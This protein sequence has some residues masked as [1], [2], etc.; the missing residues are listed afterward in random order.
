MISEV[1]NGEALQVTSPL[2]RM[3]NE[4]GINNS[5]DL[6]LKISEQ[7]KLLQNPEGEGAIAI[8]VLA[9]LFTIQQLTKNVVQQHQPVRT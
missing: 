3:K 9:V 5:R 6:L 2:A 1:S 8:I 7:A 4:T